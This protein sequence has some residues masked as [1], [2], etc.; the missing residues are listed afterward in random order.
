MTHHHTSSECIVQASPSIHEVH[1]HHSTRYIE[2][3]LDPTVQRADALDQQPATRAVQGVRMQIAHELVSVRL[4]AS[5]VR[6]GIRKT[7]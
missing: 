4:N 3:T 6:V 7:D 5:A 1:V 2:R